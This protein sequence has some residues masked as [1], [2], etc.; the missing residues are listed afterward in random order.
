VLL[1][2]REAVAR[3][4]ERGGKSSRV[5]SQVAALKMARVRGKKVRARRSILYRPEVLP[6]CAGHAW[7]R[8]SEVETGDTVESGSGTAKVGDDRWTPPVGD[9]GQRSSEAGCI[10]PDAEL[11]Y[12]L[13]CEGGLGQGR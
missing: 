1:V 8:V 11:G 7:R 4:I 12:D 5:R 2:D 10:G 9:S 6:W 3:G 13:R